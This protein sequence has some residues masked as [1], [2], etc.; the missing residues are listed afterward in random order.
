MK[1]VLLGLFLTI[2]IIGCKQSKTTP[3]EPVSLYDT[4]L[5]KTV[6]MSGVFEDSKTFV[7]LVPKKD[8]ATLE[9]E[10]LKSKDSQG[11]RLDSFVLK[12]F[13]DRSLKGLQFELDTTKNM[14]RHISNMWDVLKRN[15]DSVI[16]NSSRIALPY[17]YIVPGGRFQE[18]Y[19]WDSYFTLEG[20]LVDGEE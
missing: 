17:N 20:L 12:N 18:I 8:I 1:K 19:Y 13:E 10:Y 6:Q 3:Q 2:S 14:Y 15:P 11:F 7:D 4:E 16:S 5:F 9:A